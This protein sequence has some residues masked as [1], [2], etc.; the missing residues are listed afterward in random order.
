MCHLYVASIYRTS[1]KNF[2]NAQNALWSRTSGPTI[3]CNLITRVL[4]TCHMKLT[5]RTAAEQKRFDLRSLSPALHNLCNL[6]TQYFYI[7]VS[8]QLQ[9]QTAFLCP[10]GV[11]SREPPHY[12]LFCHCQCFNPCLRCL[13]QIQL[14]YRFFNAMSLVKVIPQQDFSKLVAVLYSINRLWIH[15]Y[16]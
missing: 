4:T 13:L 16:W 10:E 9:L 8:S 12:L 5:Q 6:Q 7:P 3:T 2:W 15:S 14:L 1:T 11:W